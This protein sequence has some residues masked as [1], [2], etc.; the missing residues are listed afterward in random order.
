M[1][2]ATLL[3]CVLASSAAAQPASS[4]S[5]LET[6]LG[7]EINR[8]GL[9]QATVELSA[10]WPSG[11]PRSADLET[12][13]REMIGTHLSGENPNRVLR[14]EARAWGGHLDLVLNTTADSW[15]RFRRWLRRSDVDSARI[16]VPLDAELRTYVA[17]RAVLTSSSIVA[18]TY[19]LSDSGYLDMVVTNLDGQDAPEL[20]ALRPEEVQVFRLGSTDTGRRRLRLVAR[21]PIPPSDA[22]GVGPRRFVGTLTVDERGVVGRVRHRLAPFRVD[23]NEGAPQVT[24]LSNDPCPAGAHAL[25]D[26]CAMPVD[27]R[28]YF[29]SDLLSRVGSPPPQRAST[30]FYQ[31]QARWIRRP[32]GAADFV[33]VVVTPRGRLVSR[34]GENAV[35][36]AGYGAG[37]GMADVDRDGNAE[38]IGASSNLIGSGDQLRVLRIMRNGALR[39]LWQSEPIEGSVLV[40]GQGDLDGDALPELLAIEEHEGRA[41]L[42]V[43]R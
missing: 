37:V 12:R 4:L 41:R 16:R 35:G 25:P 8:L 15:L 43:V 9:N 5:V 40:G 23:W 27:G 38:L 6:R 31:R 1:R 20:I 2:L 33:E 10:T 11:S 21:A 13:L 14:I 7:E 34:T 29:A 17:T 28:D 3:V 26:A 42:W 22:P 19:P 36:L 18:R 30:S 39:R 24:F 32:D